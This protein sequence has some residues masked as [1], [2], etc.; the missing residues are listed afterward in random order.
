LQ[1]M[2][3]RIKTKMVL[4]FARNVLSDQNKNAPVFV[5]VDTRRDKKTSSLITCGY[6]Q[7]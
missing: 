3:C 6:Q 2:V 7:R 1:E 4:C 5:P